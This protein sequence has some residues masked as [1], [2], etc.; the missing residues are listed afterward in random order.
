MSQNPNLNFQNESLTNIVDYLD[1]EA[2]TGF[3]RSG[4]RQHILAVLKSGVFQIVQ[5]NVQRGGSAGDIPGWCS[6]SRGGSSGA[7]HGCP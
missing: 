6:A 2:S 3:Q 1:G 4:T 7:V 5:I